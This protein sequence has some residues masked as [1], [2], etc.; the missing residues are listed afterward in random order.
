MPAEFAR[1]PSPPDDVSARSCPERHDRMSHLPDA[2]WIAWGWPSSFVHRLAAGLC[3][4]LWRCSSAGGA[5]GWPAGST[6][7]APPDTFSCASAPDAPGSPG[8]AQRHGSAVTHPSRLRWHRRHGPRLA[9]KSGFPRSRQGDD[10]MRRHGPELRAVPKCSSGTP[11][12]PHVCSPGVPVRHPCCSGS[13]QKSD[14]TR[15]ASPPA[16]PPSRCR[17]AA[18]P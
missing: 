2:R 6:M 3:F 1:D 17:A 4:R 8:P 13:S 9:T 15:A 12:L 7:K 5:A 10:G 14:G 18:L 11:P 16:A